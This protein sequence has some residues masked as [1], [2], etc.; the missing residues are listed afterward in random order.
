MNFR[1]CL[2]IF[3][4]ILALSAALCGCMNTGLRDGDNAATSP[5]PTATDGASVMPN[6]TSAVTAAFD[7]MKNAG[8]VEQKINLLSEIESSR[9]VVTGNTAL[10][11]VTFTSQYQGEMTSRIRDLVASEVQQADPAIKTV[12]VTSE[13]ED[14]DKINDIADRMAKGTP[15]SELESEIDTIVRN[16]TTMQY[17]RKR[18]ADQTRFESGSPLFVACQSVCAAS[19]P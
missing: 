19:S 3:V 17:R 5:T 2:S 8:S 9:V 18:A 7:W 10:V 4:C 11:G 6:N 15:E 12:A 14:V 13:K 16:V 1:K